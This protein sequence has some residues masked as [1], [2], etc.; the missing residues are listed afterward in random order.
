MPWHAEAFRR[1]EVSGT[2][3]ADLRALKTATRR[4]IT[5]VG[6]L[7]A[8]ATVCRVNKSV[9]AAAYDPH[10]PDRFLP[11]DVVADLELVAA[12]PIVTAVLARLA[13]HALVPLATT[14]GQEAQALVAVFRGASDVGAEFAGAMADGRLSRA[15]RGAISD[16]LMTLQAAAM[17]A[18][19]A[20]MQDQEGDGHDVG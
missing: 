10:Q 3:P 9:L 2:T 5:A 20:L 8:A 17:Q 19:A 7:E 6:G 12:E 16:R 18:V 14:G 13:G 1:C 15:E 11:I 4:L